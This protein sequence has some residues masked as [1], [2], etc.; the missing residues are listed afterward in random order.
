MKNTERI[1]ELISQSKQNLESQLEF[2]E[3]NSDS[4]RR[5]KIFLALL[6][7]IWIGITIFTNFFMEDDD[8]T[9]SKKVV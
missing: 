3:K 1:V 8:Q 7:L 5:D 4:Q 9:S 2:E 6:V